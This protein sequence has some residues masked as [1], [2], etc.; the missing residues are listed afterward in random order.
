ME[1]MFN[2]KLISLNTTRDC[3]LRF[4]KMYIA[5]KD[6]TYATSYER[7][8]KQIKQLTAELDREIAAA[9]ARLAQE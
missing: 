2:Y 7:H 8:N 9:R 3:M 1:A 4:L 5:T 6:E